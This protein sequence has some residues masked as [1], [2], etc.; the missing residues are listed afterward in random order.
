[1]GK[2]ISKLSFRLIILLTIIG[3]G[4]TFAWIY[5]EHRDITLLGV[6]KLDSKMR[7]KLDS[8]WLDARIGFESRLTFPIID[9]LQT[10]NPPQLD[11]AAW[12][13]IAGDH[14]CSS[15][16]MLH[17]ILYTDWILEVAAVAAQLKIDLANSKNRHKRVNA[18]RDS[19][20][21]LQRADPR[22]ATRAGSNNVHF[23]LALPTADTEV[24][25]YL[26]ACLKEGAEL[27]ALG[28]Y[29]WFHISALQ[30]AAKYFNEPVSGKTR[31]DLIRSAFADEA[32][33]LH[34]LEDAFASG[35]SSVNRHTAFKLERSLT[36]TWCNL[37]SLVRFINTSGYFYNISS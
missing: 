15:D 6:Q 18:L 9:T 20:I 27:N 34:F 7:L 12:P 24:K 30:K 21:K 33:A 17:N 36:V 23:L 4:K 35:Y 28:A 16:D 8:L 29:A 1:M 19:D 2:V 37:R 13:A 14:S 31:S 25:E 26:I 10:L 11:F 22:Y 32:F 3:C 5:P